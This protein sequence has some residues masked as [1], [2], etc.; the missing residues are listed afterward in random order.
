MGMSSFQREGVR[1]INL[2]S[3]ILGM[4]SFQRERVLS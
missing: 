2:G 1:E 4:S 3:E